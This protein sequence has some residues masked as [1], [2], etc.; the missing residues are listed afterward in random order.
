MKDTTLQIILTSLSPIAIMIVGFLIKSSA[1]RQAAKA[2]AD[3]AEQSKKLDEYN[4][5]VDGNLTKM[6]EIT[7]KLA[8]A[9]ATATEKE[10]GEVK[11]AELKATIAIPTTVP[12]ITVDKV[13]VEAK[14]VN[15]QKPEDKK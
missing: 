9:E 10:K 7:G 13:V 6:L 1:D 4:I 14:E 8:A 2:T 15:I 11:A 5:K 12:P 3:R